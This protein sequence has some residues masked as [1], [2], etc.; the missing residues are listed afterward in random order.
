M[1]TRPEAVHLK[2]SLR[3]YRFFILLN[4]RSGKK[5]KYDSKLKINDSLLRK[6]E[7]FLENN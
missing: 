4:L 5:P 2:E 6:V 7:F 1:F 3:K